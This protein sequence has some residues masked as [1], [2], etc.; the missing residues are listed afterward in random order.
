M[1]C[2]AQ[3]LRTAL[4]TIAY[5]GKEMALPPTIPTSFVP[6]S[7]SAQTRRFHPD[8]VGAFG[9]F[10]YTVLGIALALAI[11]VFFYG[12]ILAATQ[13][14]KDAALQSAEA[15]INPA[16][17]KNF[18]RLQNR[19]SSSETL[20]A[21]HIALSGFFTALEALLPTTV[22]LTTLHLSFHSGVVTLTGS[23]VAKSF[24]A[25]AAT[26]A[27]FAA[28]GRIKDAIF[29]N[30]VI[31]SKDNSVSFALTATLDPKL[32]AFSPVASTTS[33]ATSTPTSA[34]AS[35]TSS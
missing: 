30:I 2:F 21:N 34:T 16:I 6:H 31:R 20:L 29:S 27:S 33:T 5:T 24:N 35:T 32:V 1:L 10:A 8:F 19:L 4:A 18:V 15:T 26:S 9:F 17:A 14:A 22:R 23:G 12:R 11:G 7:A 25:L 3:I 28:D 13:S